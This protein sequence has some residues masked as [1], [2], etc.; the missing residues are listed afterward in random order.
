MKSVEERENAVD[1]REDAVLNREGATDL[2]EEAARLREGASR[3]REEVAAFREH[4]TILRIETDAAEGKDLARR[5]D[6]MRDANEQLVVATIRAQALAEA[7]EETHRRQEE[8]LAMLAHEL[9][10]PLAPIRNAAA[11]LGRIKT[12][13]PTLPWALDIINR[14]IGHM[15]RLLDDLFDAARL[16][17][18]KITLQTQPVSLRAFVE[19]AVETCRPLIV[20]RVQQLTVDIP[21]EPAYI[22]G[23]PVRLTQVF[24]NLLNNAAKYTQEGGA[25]ALS[26]QLRDDAVVVQVKDN[27]SGIASEALPRI[28]DLFTQA[29]Q[30]GGAIG[31]GL[32]IGLTVVRQ[33]VE[34]H[35]GTV[36]GYSAGLGQGSE[37]VVTLPMLQYV[38]PETSASDKAEVTSARP[39]FRVVVIDDNIDAND[40]LRMLLQMAG[41]EVSAAYDGAAALSLV[42]ASRPQIVL[43]DIGLPKLDGYAVVTK[44]REQMKDAMLLMIAITGRGKDTDRERALSAGFDHHLVKPVEPE[45]LL[46]M[47][48]AEGGRQRR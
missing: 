13:E 8:F 20:D 44:L 11:I 7:A 29:G 30:P 37:F 38:A 28:F 12:P 4:Y 23:D 43:C 36:E 18:G 31:G 39:S 3:M 2:R 19:Q 34:M 46:Q 45:V 27:G 15:T 47:I 22:L 5:V 35:G 21:P 24:S 17:S 9:R 42:Q 10:N 40:S 33:V 25:I 48:A 14:Q 1:S 32:G 41:H 16:S 6:Q 26:A